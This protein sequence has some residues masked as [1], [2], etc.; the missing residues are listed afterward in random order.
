MEIIVCKSCEKKQHKENKFCQECG[1]QLRC[2]SCS[3]EIVLGA[4][5]CIECGVKIGSNSSN[6]QSK[7]T[8]EFNETRESRTIKAE[9]SN[10]IGEKLTETLSQVVS[11]KFENKQIG[12]KS[13]HSNSQNN[14]GAEGD[15]FTED[16]GY[17]DV[18]ANNGKK[19]SYKSNE[20]GINVIFKYS[21]GKLKLNELRL[22][23]NSK[24]DY[25][26]RLTYLA[27]LFYDENERGAM[28]KSVL[29]DLLKSAGLYDG[30]YRSW[31]SRCKDIT[32]NEEGLEFTIPS[33]EKAK[34]YLIE[35]NNPSLGCKWSLG[36]STRRK[37]SKSSGNTEDKSKPST[38]RGRS[39]TSD[40][41]GSLLNDIDFKPKGRKS[42]KDFWDEHASNSSLE[43][44]L[45]FVYYFE[46]ILKIG[47]I[48]INHIYT[49]Y[50]EVGEKLP[51]NLYR[52][53]RNTESKK[54]WIKSNGIN[55]ITVTT[56]GENA[57]EFELI[58]KTE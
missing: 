9:F 3:S 34:K 16:T 1:A 36:D 27:I 29:V 40:P 43:K 15:E 17:E 25:A 33:R 2:L 26:S 22:K 14:D 52:S 56:R 13:V 11:S 41:A 44:N 57:A 46:K 35:I 7:N 58:P 20:S 38:S 49:A 39:S 24:S 5:F 51:G 42:L 10:E 48:G 53:L 8:F 12:G 23:A 31:F 4:L 55:D 54:G 37:S 30:N 32:K 45:L 47:S 28:P 18:G 50:K 19:S 21:D 6:S